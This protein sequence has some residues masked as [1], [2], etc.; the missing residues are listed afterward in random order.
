MNGCTPFLYN[1]KHKIINLRILLLF[2]LPVILPAAAAADDDKD[3]IVAHKDGKTGMYGYINKNEAERYPWYRRAYKVSFGT[4]GISGGSKNE[5]LNH[6]YDDEWVISAQYEDAAKRFSEGLA[7]VQIHGKVGFVDSL[8]RFVIEPR[9]EAVKNLDGFSQG[10]A[11]VKLNGK[12]GYINKKGTF[13]IKPV[14]EYAENFKPCRLATVKQ[15]GKFG[16]I[17]MNGYV[18]V[19]CKYLV[20]EAMINVPISNKAYKEAR[21][22]TE[23]DHDAGKFAKNMAAIDKAAQ[24]VDAL[25]ANPEWK[26]KSTLKL[27]IKKEG[28]SLGAWQPDETCMLS[29]IYDNIVCQPDNMLFVEA[30]GKWG[31]CDQYGRSI[32]PT[33]YD[34][35]AYDSDTRTLTVEQNG[36]TGLYNAT[37]R[38]LLPP[39]LDEVGRFVNGKASAY[40]NGE[41]GTV[42]VMGELSDDLMAR[43][44][45]KAATL[46]EGGAKKDDMMP[47]YSQLLLARPDYAMAHN[48]IGIMEIEG[49]EFKTG[50]N[51]LKVAHK[52]EPDNEEIAGNL[53]QAKKDRSQRRWSRISKALVVAAAAVTVAAVTYNA[54]ETAKH[55]T[56]A[57]LVDVDGMGFSGNSLSGIETSGDISSKD[58]VALKGEMAAI[59]NQI[60]NLQQQQVT[61][62]QTRFNNSSKMRS[63]ALAIA[64]S[65]KGYSRKT[66]NNLSKTK[67]KNRTQAISQ[68]QAPYSNQQNNI[69][70]QLSQIKQTEQE[71][72]NRRR[73]IE[74]RIAELEGTQKELAA[75]RAETKAKN[76]QKAEEFKAKAREGRIKVATYPAA[77]LAADAA[78]NNNIDI[79]TNTGK[80]VNAHGIEGTV[81][82]YNRNEEKIKEYEE[83]Y[84]G[85]KN[86]KKKEKKK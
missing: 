86:S 84:R 77:T 54:V 41:H 22:Q 9:Y 6:G 33:E 23:K 44:F 37:G 20:E 69:D 58:L 2:V 11:A 45:A 18:V 19:P 67:I 30:G 62:L 51:R 66:S 8:N 57:N 10:L 85:K 60:A 82:I 65:K 32:L 47:L 53:K 83:K 34:K 74:T 43:A 5:M 71:L 75:R 78:R 12:Y 40:I 63:N 24:D 55:G 42:D 1:M 21:E 80:W 16:A 64:G 14:F 4:L 26:A 48:N 27:N 25:I 15:N 28:E 68:A 56:S 50:I 29:P 59:D 79:E 61:L 17:N 35:I 7:G 73:Q 72:R 3:G 13:V 38:M 52:L 81:D 39:C 46:D 76:K 70:K 31:V 49:E 36:K